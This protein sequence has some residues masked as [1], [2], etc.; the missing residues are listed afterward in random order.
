M[1]SLIGQADE[2]ELLPTTMADTNRGHQS[3]MAIMGA[4]TDETEEPT[5]AQLSAL[6]K[7]PW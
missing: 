2:S 4:A 1:G 7:E 5:G 6:S 3:Y